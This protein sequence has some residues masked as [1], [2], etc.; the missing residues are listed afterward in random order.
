MVEKTCWWQQAPTN[1][2][3]DVRLV[4][5]RDF[6]IVVDVVVFVVGVSVVVVVFVVVVV[7]VVSC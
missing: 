4:P 5:N 3:H 6:C 2:N 7:V 1:R